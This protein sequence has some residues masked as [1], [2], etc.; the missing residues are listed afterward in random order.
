MIAPD[1][2]SVW[3]TREKMGQNAGAVE[4]FYENLLRKIQRIDP[5]TIAETADVHYKGG[6]GIPRIVIPFLASWFTLD[7]LPYRL[8]AEH[9]EFDTLAM[10]VLVLQHLITASENLGSAVRVMNQWIDPRSLQF[11]AILGAH[12]AK[13]TMEMLDNIFS[14][15]KDSAVAK[16]L[17]WGGRPNELGDIGFTFY[18]FPRLPVAL[19]HWNK[20]EEFP[21]YSK[22]LYDVSASNYMPTHGL[23]ALTDYLIHR[24]AED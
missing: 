20:D 3:I 6:D 7:L 23:T 18:L 24:L 13:S 14:S 15:G 19:I 12:F 1:E 21:P 5:I 10:K 4:E 17:K 11:G 9:S 2:Y 22:I 8:R 16:A